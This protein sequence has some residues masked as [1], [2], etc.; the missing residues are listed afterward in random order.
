M[1]QATQLIHFIKSCSSCHPFLIYS[2]TL[3]AEFIIPVQI[4]KNRHLVKATSYIQYHVPSPLDISLSTQ[5]GMP[6]T[7]RVVSYRVVGMVTRKRYG[8]YT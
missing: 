4:R 6:R 2:P 7:Y 1:E 3:C 8:L 5:H